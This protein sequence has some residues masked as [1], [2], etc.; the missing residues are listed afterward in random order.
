MKEDE[1]MWKTKIKWAEQN[2]LQ[3][4]RAPQKK[5]LNIHSHTFIQGTVNEHNKQISI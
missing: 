5:T 2:K 1:I 4:E 3:I